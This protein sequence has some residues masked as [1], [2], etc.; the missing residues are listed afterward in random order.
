MLTLL[1][2]NMQLRTERDGDMDA[3]VDLWSKTVDCC[4]LK[5]LGSAHLLLTTAYENNDN[6]PCTLSL[7]VLSAIFQVNPSKP[8]FVEAK[9]DGGGDDNWSYKSCKA[10]VKS[11]PPTNQHP[12]FYRPDALPV[13]QPTV[14]KY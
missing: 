1:H 12:V 9:D 13:A 4:G 8:M 7:S 5:I 14:S 3:V 11:S 10:P 6:L 2:S